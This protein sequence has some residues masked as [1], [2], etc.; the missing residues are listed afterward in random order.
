MT[1][2]TR[3]L[4]WLGGLVFILGIVVL[5][6]RSI[7][8]SEAQRIIPE[9]QPASQQQEMA[10]SSVPVGVAASSTTVL[11]VATTTSVSTDISLLVVGDIMLDRNVAARTKK[12]GN[13]RYPFLQLPTDWVSGFDFSLANLE[14]PVTPVRR[15][16]V[17]SIDFQFDPAWT[18]VLRSE[19]W[20]GFSQANNHALDQG[21]IGYADSVSR[22]RQAGFV[23]FGH[24]VDDGL[25][26]LAT[27]TIKGER[28]AFLGW[29]NT[30]N[31]VNRVQAAEA[32]ATAKAESDLVIAYLH[33]GNEYRDRPDA[34]NVELAHWLIDQGV[35]I[36]IGG[37]PHW[38]QGFSS[39][40]GKPIVWSL[41]NFIFDQD[42]S[43]ETQQGLAI[44]LSIAPETIRI[45]PVPLSIKAS[46]PKKEG[47]AMLATRLEALAKISD[48]ELQQ[49]IKEGKELVFARDN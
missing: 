15:P 36:V 22:L 11:P 16:P 6:W 8:P 31:P 5:L 2:K 18:G 17:K 40:K 14:G 24:Q 47:G 32:I 10:T 37:H 44:E 19:G 42:W 45:L 46:Q 38:V 49:M 1:Q 43:K 29:N 27:T 34:Q 28:F 41:G 48:K 33:W 26:A 35:D 39:Y 3:S 4:V 21:S 12:S 30:D 9:Q 23:T 13:P 7:T 20:D 25:I